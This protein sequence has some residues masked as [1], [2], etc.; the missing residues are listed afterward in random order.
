MESSKK[1][2]FADYAIE[3]FYIDFIE[4][5]QPKKAPFVLRTDDQLAMFVKPLTTGSNMSPA[6]L[7]ATSVYWLGKSLVYCEDHCIKLFDNDIVSVISGG[8]GKGDVDGPASWNLCRIQ[9]EHLCCRF[10]LC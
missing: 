5:G 4:Q 2:G 10:W 6:S 1:L 8:N 3:M 9:Q 7:K